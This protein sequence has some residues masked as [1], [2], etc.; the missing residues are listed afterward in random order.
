MATTALECRTGQTTHDSLLQRA[1]MGAAVEVRRYGG[2]ESDG[3]GTPAALGDLRRGPG[4]TGRRDQLPA[5]YRVR[6][7]SSLFS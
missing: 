3:F 4:A 7:L 2:A 1:A 6:R 5:A